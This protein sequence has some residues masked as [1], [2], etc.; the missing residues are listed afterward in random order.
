MSK[1]RFSDCIIFLLQSVVDRNYFFDTN[2]F[3][4]LLHQTHNNNATY[5]CEIQL[6]SIFSSSCVK[7][8][9][10]VNCTWSSRG[11]LSYERK[12]NDGSNGGLSP[13]ATV[14]QDETW[15]FSKKSRISLE[16][17]QIVSRLWYVKKKFGSKSSEVDVVY[18]CFF[19]LPWKHVTC[20][21]IRYIEGWQLWELLDEREE[22]G[23][24]K[25]GD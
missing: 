20:R 5:F 6:L 4:L 23:T 18:K 1:I 22:N 9:S 7:W 15:K 12:R 25:E 11:G 3:R 14:C 2:A 19:F 10:H 17:G 24:E 8:K 21:P 16:M 13:Q